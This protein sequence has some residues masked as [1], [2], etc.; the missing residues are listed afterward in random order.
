M[1]SL[2]S[3]AHGAAAACL[4]LAIAAAHVPRTVHASEP[5][6]ADKASARDAYLAGMDLRAKKDHKGA[7]EKFKAAYALLPTPITA[8]E[9]GKSLIDLGQ[10][11]E[12]NEKL[13]EAASMPA[14][15]NESADAKKA[16]AEAKASADEVEGRI[17]SITVTVTGAPEGSD[18]V[19]TIDGRAVPN[20][21]LA[22]P[23]RLNPGKHTIVARVEGGKPS[24]TTV[25]LAERETREV[26]L[27][28]TAPTDTAAPTKRGADTKPK[29]VEPAAA[30]NTWAYV[31]FGLAGAG[32]V[33]GGVTGAMAMSKKSTLNGE[34]TNASCGPQNWGDVDSYNRLRYT[35]F[36]TLAVGIVGI[37]IGVVALTAGASEPS[38]RTGSVTAYVG[39]GTFGVRGA[40]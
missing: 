13:L 18:L 2:S 9:I 35:S 30:T 17:P 19:V 15:P 1:L 8:L 39:I 27:S 31:G 14:K 21:A 20:E 23:R 36:A 12:G 6:P 28:V 37:G 10:L 3:R 33:I 32:L 11:V 7:L 4:A 24:E 16:R 34:C 40:F 26:K 25:T 22:A 5:T 38:A 29:H